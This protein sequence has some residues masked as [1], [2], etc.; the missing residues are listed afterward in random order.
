MKPKRKRGEALGLA[1][2]DMTPDETR[3]WE[4]IEE[5]YPTQG[6]NFST[7]SAQPRKR[8]PAEAARRFLRICRDAPIASGDGQRMTPGFLADATLHWLAQRR[9]EARGGPPCVPNFENFF[10]LAEGET[11]HWQN[12]VLEFAALEVP[13]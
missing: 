7:R 13:A 11:R 10:Q 6:W 8:N 2:L 9:A 5:A 1:V 4:R 12:A 3:A